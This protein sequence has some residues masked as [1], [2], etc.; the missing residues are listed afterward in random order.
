[1]FQRPSRYI[2]NEINAIHK[3]ADLRMALAFP[4]VYEVGMSH[5]G[6]RILYSI[7]NEIPYAAA[8]RVFAP[9][10]D[11]DEAMKAQGELLASLESGRPLR[12]FDIVGFSLQ[13]EL[14]YTTVLS[15]LDRGGIPLRTADRLNNTRLPLDTGHVGQAP[16]LPQK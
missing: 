11:L 9:W 16:G 12:D 6:L 5:L 1:L 2:D 14:A 8:E 10:G 4:D 7:I 3:S 13:Y 15:M